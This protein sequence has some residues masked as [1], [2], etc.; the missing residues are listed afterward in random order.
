MWEH[1]QR[2]RRVI[3]IL[4]LTLSVATDVAWS[5]APDPQAI[6]EVRAG[7]RPVAQASWWGFQP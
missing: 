6:E 3:V 7:K 2:F 1:P 5:A 4:A